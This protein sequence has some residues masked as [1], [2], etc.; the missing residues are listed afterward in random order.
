MGLTAPCNRLT[1]WLGRPSS[2]RSRASKVCRMK[3]ELTKWKVPQSLFTTTAIYI[4]LYQGPQRA[5]E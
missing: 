4:G 2:S 1:N 5:S 3:T